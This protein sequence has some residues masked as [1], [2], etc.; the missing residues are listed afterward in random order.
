LATAG[1]YLPVGK[2]SRLDLG[3]PQEGVS[4]GEATGCR[5]VSSSDGHAKPEL[6][7]QRTDNTR[8]L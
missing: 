4:A 6:I 8:L 5:R 1:F 3:R 7:A 2:S